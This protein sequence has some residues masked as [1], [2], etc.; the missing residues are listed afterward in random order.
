MTT[1][2]L[3]EAVSSTQREKGTSPQSKQEA[4]NTESPMTFLKVEISWYIGK[5]KKKCNLGK[6]NVVYWF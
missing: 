1:A 4:G 2:Q 5:D 6:Q 3:L